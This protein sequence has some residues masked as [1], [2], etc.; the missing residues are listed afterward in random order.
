MACYAT[1]VLEQIFAP[2]GCCLL[3]VFND[4]MILSLYMRASFFHFLKIISTVPFSLVISCIN[5]YKSQW[6]P[7]WGA[8]GK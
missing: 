3:H 1:K 8:V 4:A 7:T 2:S 5:V 6:I